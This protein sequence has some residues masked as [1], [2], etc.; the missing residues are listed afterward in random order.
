LDHLLEFQ[1]QFFPETS[2]NDNGG[3]LNTELNNIINFILDNIAQNVPLNS[4]ITVS[5]FFYF[6][7]LFVAKKIDQKYYSLKIKN[8]RSSLNTTYSE[9]FHEKRQL[10]YGKEIIT[11]EILESDI[12]ILYESVF[13][14]KLIN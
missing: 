8:F 14:I 5:R 13:M 11:N 7:K 4:F 2:L 10:E 9:Y 3:N 6:V 1:N 12:K